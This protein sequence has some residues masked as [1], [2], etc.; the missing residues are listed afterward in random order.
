[1]I[2]LL[3]AGYAA[4]SWVSP[5]FG[6]FGRVLRDIKQL[7]CASAGKP[8]AYSSWNK[9]ASDF[10]TAGLEPCGGAIEPPAALL[11]HSA[12][13]LGVS[14]AD[15]LDPS[16]FVPLRRWLWWLLQMQLPVWQRPNV[17]SCC[18]SPEGIPLFPLQGTII[19]TPTLPCSQKLGKKPPAHQY[20]WMP[21]RSFSVCWS[22][23]AERL[24]S[25][26]FVPGQGDRVQEALASSLAPT[27]PSISLSR[28][29]F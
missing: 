4:G 8:G 20:R 14:Q 28:G 2:I 12:H 11:C 27:L 13:C 7:S 22:T 5:F 23:C 16:Q 6:F 21:W 10:V 29:L 24:P 25:C 3:I 19:S 18:S 1:M 15:R 17:P 9:R 26:D